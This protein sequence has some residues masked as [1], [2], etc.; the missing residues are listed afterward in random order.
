VSLGACA[1][2]VA[3]FLGLKRR[4]VYTP[5]SG[6]AG[7]LLR[8]GVALVALAAA[9]WL[10]QRHLDWTALQSM[11][12]QRAGML[13]GVVVGAAAVYFGALFALG[14]RARDFRPEHR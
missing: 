2:A 13:A 11:P 8:L 6:W 12:W 5:R 9:L 10:V 3:L 1:N 14:F 4:G 7:F